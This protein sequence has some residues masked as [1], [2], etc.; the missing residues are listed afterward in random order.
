MHRFIIALCVAIALL[1]YI[2]YHFRQHK[3]QLV[4]SVPG[5]NR[6][7]SLVLGIVD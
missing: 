5:T 2:I 1:V 4:M 3:E 6:Q 7:R